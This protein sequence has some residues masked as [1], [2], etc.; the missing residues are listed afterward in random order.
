AGLL[1]ETTASAVAPALQTATVTSAIQFI[2]G[3]ASPGPV[4]FLA[5]GV[6]HA[7]LIAKIKTVGFAMMLVFVA[8]GMFW[9]VYQLESDGA[10]AI[11]VAQVARGQDVPREQRKDVEKKAADFF[12][13][14]KAIDLKVGTLTV[15]PLRDGDT[16]DITF[17]LGSK[18]LK[19]ESTRGQALKLT[20]LA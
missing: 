8:S 6:L 9:G 13:M 11:G 10:S 1:S 7:M 12:G 3:S 17:N 4:V 15:Q 16:N 19:V 2:A 18:D 5:Q 20:D 14:I